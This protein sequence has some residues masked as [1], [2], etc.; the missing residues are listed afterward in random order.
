MSPSLMKRMQIGKEELERKR[1]K[2]RASSPRRAVHA[3]AGIGKTREQR[4]Q[5]KL[6]KRD[7]RNALAPDLAGLLV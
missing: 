6:H 1:Q 3:V 7:R 4:L 2:E 5:K